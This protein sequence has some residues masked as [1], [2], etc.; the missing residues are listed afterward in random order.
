MRK[1]NIIIKSK[2]FPENAEEETVQE[3]LEKKIDVKT[4]LS[5]I[6]HVG[7]GKEDTKIKN[8]ENEMGN[9]R[10]ERGRTSKQIRKRSKP[11]LTNEGETKNIETE[12]NKFKRNLI[13]SAGKTIGRSDRERRKEWID[14]EWKNAT[15]EKN[16]AR[17]K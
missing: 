11:K 4:K 16:N 17:P 10:T 5:E 1:I 7:A 2:D 8:K 3:F 15:K 14:D 12:W 9:E 6:Q 13:D